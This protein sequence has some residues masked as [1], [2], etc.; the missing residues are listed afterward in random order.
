MADRVLTA[1]Y[2]AVM[3]LIIAAHLGPAGL[4]IWAC[5][6]CVITYRAT[7][8][9]RDRGGKLTEGTESCER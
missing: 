4:A 1:V 9:R 3:S 6:W 2:A 7:S 8:S 5:A